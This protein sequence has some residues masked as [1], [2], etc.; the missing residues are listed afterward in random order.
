MR[1]R[2]FSGIAVIALALASCF[3]QAS[4][5]TMAGDGK[6]ELK[7]AD[8]TLVPVNGAIVSFYRTD[9][10]GKPITVKTGKDGHYTLLGLAL[11]GKYTITVSAPGARP[12]Y[13]SNV[14][15]NR[16]PT[17]N[18]VLDVGDGSSLTIEQINQASAAAGTGGDT[19]A[20]KAARE[21]L[22]RKNKEITEKN[23]KIK[24]SNEI[25]GRTFKA[26]NEALL[27]KR[28]DE[29]IAQYDEGLKAD[30]EQSVLYKNRAVAL[31]LR[32]VDRYNAAAKAKDKAGL[33][34]GR[35][36]FK[37]AVESSEK[38][39]KYYREVIK[40]RQTSGT[41]GQSN[42]NEELSYLFDRSEAYNL[43]L[44]T[45]AAITPDDAVKAAQE[46]Y[47]AETDPVKK[48]KAETSVGDAMFFSGHFDEAVSA[49][50]QILVKNPNNFDAMYGLGLSLAADPSGTHAAEARDVLKQFLAKAPSTHPKRQDAT[51]ALAGIESFLAPKP[52][53]PTDTTRRRRKG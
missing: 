25:V 45:G 51:E 15:I 20:A 32:G 46:Y 43:A 11:V 41:S 38:A 48:A 23:A 42:A 37:A 31:R 47:N 17:N 50:R 2:L 27:A 44:K 3:A 10:V 53:E 16:Q 4:A 12:S 19:A 14:P 8:G 29:A 28:Y 35:E 34:A 22:E 21:E 33:E 6:V 26:G 39:V 30:P 5:Q 1:F 24:E 40:Q 7:Q 9:I 36:D 49:Y 13:V 52:A 18:F